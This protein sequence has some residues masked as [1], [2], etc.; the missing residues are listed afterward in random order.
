LRNAHRLRA[1][2]GRDER[3]AFEA[4]RR[5]LYPGFQ[6]TER[7]DDHVR[8]AAD[9]PFYLVDDFVVPLASNNVA[10]G[11]DAWSR[12]INREMVARAVQTGNPAAS[13]LKNSVQDAGTSKHGISI[14][15]PVYRA[16]EQL[17]T[18][19]ARWLATPR[20]C[21]RPANSSPAG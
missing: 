20:S 21:S 13:V 17:S 1:A 10:F 9:R 4:E 19:D 3:A 18:L 8:R 7:V 5:R 12:A 15:M 2:R 6:I 14:V 11:F 16:G